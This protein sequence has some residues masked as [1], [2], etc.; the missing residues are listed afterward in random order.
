MQNDLHHSNTNFE[1]KKILFTYNINDANL[2]KSFYDLN[3]IEEQVYS[4]QQIWRSKLRAC[5]KVISQQK[6]RWSMSDQ[7]MVKG[8]ISGNHSI[9]NMK[10][11]EFD[12]DGNDQKNQLSSMKRFSPSMRAIIQAR[13][14]NIE[15]RAQQIIKFIHASSQE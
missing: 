4:T 10:Q 6:K 9:T 14:D 2:V 15:Q 11:N 12:I 1:Q 3:P 7:V 5:E 8:I 13:L